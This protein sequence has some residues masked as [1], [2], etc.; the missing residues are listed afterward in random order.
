M[1]W[2][3]SFQEYAARKD[4]FSTKCSSVCSRYTVSLISASAAFKAPPLSFC[5]LD[6]LLYTLFYSKSVKAAV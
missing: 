6:F 4:K 2:K 5:T 3:D 1:G